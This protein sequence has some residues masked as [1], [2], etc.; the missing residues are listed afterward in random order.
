[1]TVREA[2][3]I[4]SQP[5]SGATGVAIDAPIEIV[6]SHPVWDAPTNAKTFVL[7]DAAGEPVEAVVGVSGRRVVILPSEP[8]TPGAS[9]EVAAGMVLLEDMRRVPLGTFA[10]F[11]AAA[12]PALA[13]GGDYELVVDFPT[14]DVAK[15]RLDPSKTIEVRVPASVAPTAHGGDATLTLTS[16][17][18]SAVRW[19]VD[20]ETLRMPALPIPVGGVAFAN[21]WPTSGALSDADGD[22]VADAASGELEVS[23][24]GFRG[25]GVAWRLERPKP[26][27]EGSE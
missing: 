9:Y 27:V 14:I 15:G 21:G 17:L 4:T 10:T 3:L 16:D 25:K 24:P 2:H 19:V 1:M 11:E 8:L 23:G 18:V 12:A 7:K 20:G 6:L 26:P 22:G 13:L 5:R